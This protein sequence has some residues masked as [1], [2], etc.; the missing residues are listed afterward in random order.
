MSGLLTVGELSLA[1]YRGRRVV[2]HVSIDVEEGECLAVVGE[3][4]SGKTPTALAIMGLLP[5]Q[6]EMVGGQIT[7]AGSHMR[8]G[9]PGRGTSLTL[10]PQDPLSALTP[11]VSIGMQIAEM[12]TVHAGATRREARRRTI[13]LLDRVGI[14]QPSRRFAAYP[15]Q[16]S[17]GMR[18]RVLIAIAI[19]LHPRLL[20]ADEPT[21]ALDVTVQAQILELLAELRSEMRMAMIL[22]THDLGVVAGQSDR[23]ALMYAGRIMETA[24][25]DDFFT[26]PVHPYG[27]ALLESGPR[28]GSGRMP[29]PIP[30]S[31]PHA[32]N[33]PHGCRFHPR[34]PLAIARCLIETPNLRLLGNALVA[35][36]R[37]G[38]TD[39]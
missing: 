17:G 6:I 39:G 28:I 16:L 15:H 35:C 21:T 32:A 7:F 34:C 31:P 18:Q 26:A 38:E 9:A 8:N 3:S 30:G 2:E 20:I 12:F 33:F 23:V 5:P 25:A 37:A 1:T 10:V 36:H 11:V 24:P 13:D 27:R 29:K 19:A 14:P 22:I 4:G